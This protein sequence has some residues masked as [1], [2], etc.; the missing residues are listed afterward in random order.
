MSRRQF[1]LQWDEGEPALETWREPGSF[2]LEGPMPLDDALDEI[3]RFYRDR[4]ESGT[5]YLENARNTTGCAA[6]GGAVRDGAHLDD[7]DNDHEVRT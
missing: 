5:V 1:G 6:C 3:M 4:V 2:G 7:D